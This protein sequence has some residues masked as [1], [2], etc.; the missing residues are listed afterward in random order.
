MAVAKATADGYTLL[1]S[2]PAFAVRA[3]LVSNLPYDPIK[4]FS[5]IA[6]LGYSNTVL[7]VSR[8]IGV[9]SVKDLVSFAQANPG[10]TFFSSASATSSDRLNTERFRAALG[11]KAQHVAFK[12]QAE[13]II[14][15]A[16][17]RVQ[18]TTTGMTA[19]LPFIK[20]GKLIPLLQRVNY[21]PGVPLI[22][23]VMPQWNQ[24]G[25]QL[26]LAPAAT[27]LTIRRQ[28]S[29]DVAWALSLVDIKE[30]LGAF[31][32]QVA[33]ASPEETERNLRRDI[34]AFAQVIKEIGLKP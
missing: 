8:S 32:F 7:V 5:G 26:F 15:I 33:P 30:K 14:E 25:S 28:I 1:A 27:P 17:G 12:G 21:L 10:K 16:A 6:E 34:A 13:S 18:F 11:I 24:I 19:T 22:A 20:D 23:D 29:A 3:A 9:T 2:S 31:A 4:D